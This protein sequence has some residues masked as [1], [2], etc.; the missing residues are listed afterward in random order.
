MLSRQDCRA[1]VQCSAATVRGMCDGRQAG[2]CASKQDHRLHPGEVS[3]L[4]CQRRPR[5]CLVS[6]PRC[7]AALLLRHPPFKG[8]SVFVW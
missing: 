2:C 7:P 6:L 5:P 8:K 4:R 3:L 1:S